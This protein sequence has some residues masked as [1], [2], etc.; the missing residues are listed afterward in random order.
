MDPLRSTLLAAAR[1]DRARRAMESFPPARSV[2]DRFVG[3]TTDAEVLAVARELQRAKL[4]VTIDHLGED[5]IDDAGAEAT[6]RAYETLLPQLARVGGDVSIKLTALGLSH[7]PS[8]ALERAQRVVTAATAQEVTVTVDMES[9]ALTD[10]TLSVV[11]T[12]RERTPTV[13]AV[14]QAMLRRT[15]TDARELGAA[16][17]RV[18]LC[19]GAY[20]E[21]SRAAFQRR[22][23][24]NSSYVRSLTLLWELNGTPLVATH[25]PL[26]ITTASELARHHP[27]DFE[28]Q[29]LYG[30]RPNE[31]RRLAE[32]GHTVRI[33]VPYGQQWYGYLMRRLAERPANLAFFL[34]SLGSRR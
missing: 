15:E 22:A 3:G 28:F 27:R 1:S 17:A 9:S 2:V 24:V 10:A 33:Y 5:V 7:D 11:H 16:G 8:G 13:A 30:V 34:R 21:E 18:R 12:L 6:V 4:L 29:M 31:Q 20:A 25:D 32:L 19:K 23:D 14:L 26:L